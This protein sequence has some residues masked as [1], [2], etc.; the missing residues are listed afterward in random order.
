MAVLA[1][2]RWLGDRRPHAYD[3]YSNY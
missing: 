1:G 2:G 3:A